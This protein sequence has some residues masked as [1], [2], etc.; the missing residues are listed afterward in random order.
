MQP[1]IVLELC[2]VRCHVC[3]QVFLL[4]VMA[5]TYPSSGILLSEC[6]MSGGLPWPLSNWHNKHV[7][8]EASAYVSEN[9]PTESKILWSG[10]EVGVRVVTGGPEFQQCEV[11]TIE[12]PVLVAMITYMGRVNKGRFSWDPLTTLI[13][14]RGTAAGGCVE[15]TNCAGRNS[16]NANNGANKWVL[17]P[18]SNQTYLVLEDAQVAKNAINALLCQEPLLLHKDKSP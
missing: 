15:C 2:N 12:N 17:G 16:V 3:C 1:R 18:E 8:S 5:G 14:V 4:A 13:A 10:F 6:N 11:A 9:W 7:G